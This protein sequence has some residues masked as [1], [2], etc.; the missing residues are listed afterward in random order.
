MNCTD[1]RNNHTW[2]T[3]PNVETSLTGSIAPRLMAAQVWL[4]DEVKHHW[5][6]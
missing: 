6:Y 2:M 3:V 4:L 1:V 5:I